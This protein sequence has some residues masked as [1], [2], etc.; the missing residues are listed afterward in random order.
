MADVT[1]VALSAAGSLGSITNRI[2]RG[3]CL[4]WSKAD[5]AAFS[6][7]VRFTPKSGH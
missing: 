7:N 4:L 1:E 5:M 3:E 6:N 2:G